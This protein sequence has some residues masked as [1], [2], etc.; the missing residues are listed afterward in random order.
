[1]IPSR[2]KKLRLSILT[3]GILEKENPFSSPGDNYLLIS[4]KELDDSNEPK[5][6]T[7][8]YVKSI[9]LSN[10]NVV[11]LATNKRSGMPNPQ[12]LVVLKLI[13]DSLEMNILKTLSRVN[14]TYFLELLK[15]IRT[16]NDK[17][18]AV[19]P[20]HPRGN[21][22]SYLIRFSSGIPEVQ[23][24]SLVHHML[25]AVNLCHNNKICHHDISLENILL[26]ED[27]LVP[28]LIDFGIST[29]MDENFLV[30]PTR[31]NLFGKESY[32]APELYE[33]FYEI[34]KKKDGENYRL[35]YDGRKV[36]IWSLGVILCTLLTGSLPW[37][38]PCILDPNFK[39]IV[40][41]KKI[42]EYFESFN[43][44]T[45]VS[46]QGLDFLQKIFIQ[47][48]S[49]RPTSDDLLKHEWLKVKF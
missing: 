18:Y 28:I 21:L 1:M 29:L 49:L 37:S 48:P 45:A 12:E 19:F 47:D 25:L 44:T 17:I 42:S 23:A 6:E 40:H 32:L 8:S 24:R 30:C 15:F 2:S 9:S 35:C 11:V 13:P 5:T 34:K 7:C 26:K 38:F 41:Q 46:A 3:P 14:S 27:D 43:L 22:L 20:Y 36:D 4:G 39:T 33:S 31:S 10:N 16:D